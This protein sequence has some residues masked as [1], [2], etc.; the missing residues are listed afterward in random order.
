MI[1]NIELSILAYILDFKKDDKALSKDDLYIT[2]KSG[3][4]Q[5]QQRTTGWKFLIKFKDG[6]EE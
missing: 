1:H 5:M 4:R 2:T 6:S 3:R